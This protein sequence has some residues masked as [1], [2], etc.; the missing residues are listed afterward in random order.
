[1]RVTRHSKT[2]HM[3]HKMSK[4]S[5]MLEWSCCWFWLCFANNAEQCPNKCSLMLSEHFLHIQ[6]NIFTF[7]WIQDV[8]LSC[9]CLQETI[10]KFEKSTKHALS[11]TLWWNSQCTQNSCPQMLTRKACFCQIWSF[12]MSLCSKHLLH[13]PLML[14]HGKDTKW[15]TKI[16]LS[17]YCVQ[18]WMEEEGKSK[19]QTT[20]ERLSQKGKHIEHYPTFSSSFES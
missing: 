18:C 20:F 2:F 7:H 10:G 14:L 17:K 9:A 5:K 6:Q 15:M 8:D 16:L 1:M 4:G 11:S 19:L 13:P 12:Q 3:A